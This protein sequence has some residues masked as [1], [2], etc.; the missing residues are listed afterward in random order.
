MKILVIFACF[1]VVYAQ[2]EHGKIMKECMEESGVNKDLLHYTFKTR[3]VTKDD[4]LIAFFTCTMVKYGSLNNQTCQVNLTGIKDMCTK[5]QLGDCSFVDTCEKKQ[6]A[7]CK[8]TVFLVN[9]CV[10]P[11]LPGNG[12]ENV[13]EACKN[14]SKVGADLIMKL[15][16]E[17]IVSDDPSM[18]KFLGCVTDRFGC[19]DE[20][21]SISLKYLRGIC[22]WKKCADC[23][24][25]DECEKK[26]GGSKDE[27][28]FLALSCAYPQM[29][30]AK[31]E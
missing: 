11:H 23:S 7:D 29:C 5:M 12:S 16:K 22:A 10:L 21:G 28:A 17:G 4:N 26:K 6:G 1:S 2:K 20:S 27:T 3:N 8:E 14:Q 18:V 30:K 15:H 9:Q 13:I 25:I 24:F 19:F 31:E